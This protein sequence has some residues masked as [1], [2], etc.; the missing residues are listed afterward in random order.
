M[1]TPLATLLLIEA[2]LRMYRQKMRKGPR[3]S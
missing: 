1:K 3:L 2:Y